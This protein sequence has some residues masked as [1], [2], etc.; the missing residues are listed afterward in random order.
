MVNMQLYQIHT[1]ILKPFVDETI[2]ALSTMSDLEA[3]AG[4]GYIEDSDT[5]SFMG[6]A[7]CVVAKTYGAVEGK[8]IMH[9]NNETALGIGN[10]V[11]A[12]MLGEPSEE[13]EINESVGEAL[14]EFSNTVVGLATRILG[15]ENLNITFT[16]PLYISSQEESE[17]LLADVQ[18]ILTVPIEVKGVGQFTFSYLLHKKTENVMQ[19]QLYKINSKVL[20]PFVDETV[21]ALADMADIEAKAGQGYMED[22]EKFNFNGYAVCVVA[23]IYGAIEGKVIMHHN[24]QT[25]LVIGNR[26]RTKMLGARSAEREINENVGEALTEFSN[27]VVGLATRVL[28]ERN[29]NITFSPPLYISNEGESGFLIEDVMEILTVPIDLKGIGQFTFSFLLHRTTE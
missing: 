14:T 1:K 23:K 13:Q 15:K 20:K 3:K 8:V 24:N 25:A 18:E 4:Q 29:M 11:R 12:K 9:H 6:Y 7:V 26:V 10:R 5:F 16:P 21:K 22:P 2:K 17:F 28:G 27:T 19:I